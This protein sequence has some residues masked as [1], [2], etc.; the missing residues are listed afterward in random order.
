MN[1]LVESIFFKFSYGFSVTFKLQ[2]GSKR[3]QFLGAKKHLLK[4]VC[5]SVYLSVHRP[6]KGPSVHWFVCQCVL[7]ASTFLAVLTCFLAPRSQYWFLLRCNETLPDWT[8]WSWSKNELIWCHMTLL[9]TICNANYQRDISVTWSDHEQNEKRIE[10]I[11]M[12]FCKMGWFFFVELMFFQFFMF[13]WEVN[14]S[15]GPSGHWSVSSYVLSFDSRLYMAG[16][17]DKT[18][19]G[20]LQ[21]LSVYNASIEYRVRSIGWFLKRFYLVFLEPSW[22]PRKEKIL[23]W[24]AKTKGYLWASFH[25]IWSLSTSSN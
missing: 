2:L 21:W 20:S 1:F 12:R 11:K 16:L 19:T 8:Y 25:D 15:I 10:V 7:Y 23:L 6:S 24:K 9:L 3:R 22:F 14:R 13:F 17:N 4:G 18:S 5:L